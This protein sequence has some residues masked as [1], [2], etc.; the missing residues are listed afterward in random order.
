MVRQVAYKF[1]VKMVK[2][3]M[4]MERNKK[5][6]MVVMVVVVIMGGRKP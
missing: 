6:K 5:V 1:Q 3:V 4:T 2:K